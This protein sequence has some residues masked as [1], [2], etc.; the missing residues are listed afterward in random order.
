RGRGAGFDERQR[1]AVGLKSAG[2]LIMHP[3]ARAVSGGKRHAVLRQNEERPGRDEAARRKRVVQSI[4][5]PAVRVERTRGAIVKFDVF[6]IGEDGLKHDFVENN[7]ASW[8][9]NLAS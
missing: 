4:D 5:A 9:R 1:F 3:N 8:V 2:E 6:R 7:A